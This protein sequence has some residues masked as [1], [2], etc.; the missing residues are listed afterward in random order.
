MEN[1][2]TISKVNIASLD[3]IAFNRIWEAQSDEYKS[4]SDKVAARRWFL[5][6]ACYELKRHMGMTE[7]FR[8]IVPEGMLE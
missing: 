4:I 6:G 2:Q 5:E 8:S 7:Q 3:E 1:N